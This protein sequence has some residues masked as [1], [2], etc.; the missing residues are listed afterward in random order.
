MANMRDRVKEL[1]ER[2]ARIK[3]MG[4]EE[5]VKKQH[6]RGKLTARERLDRFFDDG[7]WFEVGIHGTQMGQG[8]PKDKPPADAVV[9]GWGQ[10]DGRPVAAAVKLVALSGRSVATRDEARQILWPNG[11]GNF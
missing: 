7:A 9:C 1:E 5:K 10:V 3:Q 8:D 11:G 6:E 4:G 2:R